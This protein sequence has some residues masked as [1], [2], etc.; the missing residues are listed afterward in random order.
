M[1]VQTAPSSTHHAVHVRHDTVEQVI[2]WTSLVIIMLALVALRLWFDLMMPILT[3][4][5]LAV[6]LYAL[7]QAKVERGEPIDERLAH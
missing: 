6:V 3:F 5:L 1:A 4:A 2:V 7:S